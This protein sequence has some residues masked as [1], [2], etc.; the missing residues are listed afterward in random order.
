MAEAPMPHESGHSLEPFEFFEHFAPPLSRGG[1]AFC[2]LFCTHGAW[3]FLR[4]PA[5]LTAASA[6]G[7]LKA[8]A[9]SR[10]NAEGNRWLLTK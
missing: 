2:F 8:G 4:S 6:S 5:P 9:V 10:L 1:G 7:A 3:E